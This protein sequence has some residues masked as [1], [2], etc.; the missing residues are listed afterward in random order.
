MVEQEVLPSAI[1][2]NI[3]LILTNDQDT[4]LGSLQFMPKYMSEEGATYKHGYIST[5]MCCTSRS[6][7][8]TGKR[9]L[10]TDHDETFYPRPVRARPIRVHQQRQLQLPL[11]VRESREENLNHLPAGY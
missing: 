8:V 11:L 6:S 4:D 1:K 7:L 3:L 9:I 2:P 5:P 10:L